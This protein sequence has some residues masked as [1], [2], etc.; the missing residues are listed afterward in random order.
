M[1]QRTT[2]STET[3]QTPFWRV[4]LRKHSGWSRRR[5]I[6]CV[7]HMHKSPG[8]ARPTTSPRQTASS[9]TGAHKTG[10]RLLPAARNILPMQPRRG[11]ANRSVTAVTAVARWCPPTPHTH[12][13]HSHF[14]R[15][16]GQDEQRGRQI[17]QE[18]G[19]GPQR[20]WQCQ[21]KGAAI[22][23]A[24]RHVHA[25]HTRIFM[26]TQALLRQPPAASGTRHDWPPPL[27]PFPEEVH[28]SM[29]SLHGA[30]PATA[31]NFQLTLL[32]CC[33]AR[34]RCCDVLVRACAPAPDFFP[35]HTQAW[36]REHEEMVLPGAQGG[37]VE[38]EAA[39]IAQSEAVQH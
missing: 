4:P 20:V 14:C 2:L 19:Q 22:V 7:R 24:V 13:S 34:A 37:C 33:T 36:Q 21:N 11:C 15:C 25:T 9:C 17:Q 26:Y 35:A 12:T 3:G 1:T 27:P 6:H 8:F 28:S 18:A 38:G 10:R 16:G 29:H 31:V 5:S 39:P 23:T 32:V 30:A